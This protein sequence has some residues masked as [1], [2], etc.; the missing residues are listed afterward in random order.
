MPDLLIELLSEEIPARM[1]ARAAEDLQ[2]L[3]TD[4]L[5]A[6]GLLYDGAKAF[7]TPR[8]LALAV[9]GVP[10]PPADGEEGKRGPRGGAAEG[11]IQGFQGRRTENDQGRQG[12]E[13]RQEGRFL[14]RRDREEGAASDRGDRRDRAGG[15]ADFSVAE[16]NGLGLPE[17]CDEQW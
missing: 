6:A 7:V 3:V 2:R 9:A 5:V 8:R 13:G 16:V 14:R 17:I 12:R 1:Q 4:K 10:A 15:G 11:A